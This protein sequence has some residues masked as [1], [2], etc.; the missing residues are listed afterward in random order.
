MPRLERIPVVARLT[1][2]PPALLRDV[3][4]AQLPPEAHESDRL[5]RSG[6]PFPHAK[7]GVVFGNRE[8]IGRF[9]RSQLSKSREVDRCS[10]EKI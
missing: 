4:Y 7:D 3:A 6:G 5:I 9:A 8:R 1:A 2:N 10:E